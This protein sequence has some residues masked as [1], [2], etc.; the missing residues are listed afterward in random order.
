MVLIPSSNADVSL[1][2]Q[3]AVLPAKFYCQNIEMLDTARNYVD[4][5]DDLGLVQ[6]ETLAAHLPMLPYL[7]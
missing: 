4:V 5:N 1:N 6:M 3:L 7:P 2:A